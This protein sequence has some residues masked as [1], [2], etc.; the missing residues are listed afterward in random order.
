[1]RSFINMIRHRHFDTS[2][3]GFRSV[4]IQQKENCQFACE[5]SQSKKLRTHGALGTRSDND[6]SCWQATWRDSQAS[7]VTD[8][9]WP[10]RPLAAE[11]QPCCT[12]EAAVGVWPP[13]PKRVGGSTPVDNKG[14]DC[15]WRRSWLAL[16]AAGLLSLPV[17]EW[18]DRGRPCGES[19]TGWD[20]V[21]RESPEMWRDAWR[22]RS[23]LYSWQSSLSSWP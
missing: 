13:H 18:T 3:L 6:N 5:L 9:R 17:V 4:V 1:M 11:R 15:R 12:D 20:G 7:W 23:F 2:C 10:S 8:E 14:L 22:T 19:A 21:E 16:P